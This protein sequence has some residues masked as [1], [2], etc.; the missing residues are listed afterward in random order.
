MSAARLSRRAFLRGGGRLPL[1]ARLD[2]AE[3]VASP[4]ACGGELLARVDASRCLGSVHQ[5]CTVCR[6]H[7]EPRAIVFRGLFPRIES[8]RCTGCGACSA[9]CPAPLP[10]IHMLK[11]NELGGD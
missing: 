6:E 5:V 7:C 4:P 9:A 3:P 10:A 2:I 11:R 8:E 1:Y